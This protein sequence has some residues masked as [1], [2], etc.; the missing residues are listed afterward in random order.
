MDLADQVFKDIKKNKKLSL[1]LSGGS[2]PLKDY[3]KLFSKKN[4]WSKINFFLLDERQVNLKSKLSNF[5]KI[6]KLLKSNKLK[7]NFEPLNK[8]FLHPKKIKFTT[9]ILKKTYTISILGMGDDGHYAS[10]F[11]TSKK[12]NQLINP[13]L[14][15]KIL[16]T[17][18]LGNPKLKRITM[19]LSMILISK[20]IYLILN[21]RKKLKLFKYILRNK[22]Y[23][24]YPI[25]SLVKKARKKLY[26]SNNNKIFKFIDKFN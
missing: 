13:K 2:S 23:K 17:E 15:P 10:I 14:L 26:I 12:F 7:V 19:N 3:R 4:N 22:N 1:I 9:Q 8:K 16:S 18:K 21:S 5:Y 6:N 25:Y 20:K 11:S 24:K